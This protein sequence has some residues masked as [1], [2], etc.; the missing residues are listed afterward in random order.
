MQELAKYQPTQV[1]ETLTWRFGENKQKKLATDICTILKSANSYIQFY[2]DKK[3]DFEIFF[4]LYCIS[5]INW[6]SV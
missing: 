2:C 4:N 1:R 5:K 6:Q 3:A